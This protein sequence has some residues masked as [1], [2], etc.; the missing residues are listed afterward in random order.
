[1]SRRL[2]SKSFDTLDALRKHPYFI[3]L[4]CKGFETV[5]ILT[6]TELVYDGSWGVMRKLG[7]GLSMSGEPFEEYLDRKNKRTGD[8]EDLIHMQTDLIMLTARN[9][10][11]PDDDDDKNF[12]YLLDTKTSTHIKDE[13]DQMIELK[14]INKALDKKTQESLRLKESYM[15]QLETAQSEAN[16]YREKMSNF[17]E[18]LGHARARAEYYQTQLK[19]EQIRLMELE[20]YL[21][22]KLKNAVPSGEIQGKDSADVVLEASKK[23]WQAKKELDKLAGTDDGVSRDEFQNFEKKIFSKIDGMKTPSPVKPS[24]PTV[25]FEEENGDS[26]GESSAI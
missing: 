2:I 15:R 4:R 7:R 17:S 26:D 11:S 6:K 14:R 24:K 19:K 16:S 18:Q 1:V 10:N 5:G 8:L 20:G 3:L 23:Q 22:E 12:E 21:E 25:K 13:L 9:T